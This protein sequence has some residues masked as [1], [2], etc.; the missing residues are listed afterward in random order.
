M[1]I[2]MSPEKCWALYKYGVIKFW[3]IV[4]SC[5]ILLYEFYYDVRIYEHQMQNFLSHW[6]SF[7]PLLNT[8]IM[9]SHVLGQH[10]SPY[11]VYGLNVTRIFKCLSLWP[12]GLRPR[13]AAARFLRLWF[14]IP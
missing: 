5:W 4:A 3:Y 8:E 1:M 13:S 10:A 14:G 9:P 2:G 6:H 12:L 7:S 11:Q